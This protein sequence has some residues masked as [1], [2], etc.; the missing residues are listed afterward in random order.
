MGIIGGDRETT[1]RWLRLESQEAAMMQVE[2][3]E[4]GTMQEGGA[5]KERQ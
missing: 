4:V 5:G 3:V 1:R 2:N